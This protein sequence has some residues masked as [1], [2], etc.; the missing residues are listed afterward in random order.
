VIRMMTMDSE[1]EIKSAARDWLLRLSL[2]SPTPNDQAQFAAWCAEDPRHA[3]AYRRF[4]SIWRDTASLEAL[5]PLAS[6]P[7]ARDPWWRRVRASLVDH[8]RRWAASASLAAAICAIGVWYLL[9]PAYYA[10]GVAEVRDI[11]LSDGSEV[12]LGARSSLEVAFRLHER[13]V[14]LTC[15]VAFFSVAKNP[16]RPFIVL[17]GD[18]EVR[19][20]GTKFEIRRDPNG[21]R[22]S[23]VEGRVEVMQV[24]DR[25]SET[26][27]KTPRTVRVA[28]KVTQATSATIPNGAPM[29]PMVLTATDS[30]E[31]RILTAGQEVTAAVASAIP[32]PQVMPRGEPAAWRHGRLVYVDAPLKDI[33]A[34]ANRYS[35]E[36]IE[37]AE[38]GL[39]N[40]RVSITYPSDRIEEMVAALSRSLSLDIERRE[41]GGIVLKA[42]KPSGD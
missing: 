30:S 40:V 29:S 37:I 1:E 22:V 39:A 24:P 5:K 3:A 9:T 19:V 25:A 13:R 7:P 10:T 16:S 2:E 6:L 33:I 31:E 12:T 26:A 42:K 34:D 21:M 11:H 14:A 20:V 28:T 17:V 4:E 36:P 38:E 23:V 41:P 15:G 27:H 8:P 35:R 18:K 32:D